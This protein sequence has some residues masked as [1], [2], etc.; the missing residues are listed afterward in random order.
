MNRIVVLAFASIL[1]PLQGQVARA[2]PTIDAEGTTY[3]AIIA[4]AGDTVLLVHGMFS[5]RRAWSGLEEAIA[6]GHRFVAYTQRGFGPDSWQ[7]ATFSRD[8]HTDDLVAILEAL[9]APAD[10]VGWSYGG[11]IVLGAAA[12]VPDRVR[13][14]VVY[15]PFVPELL[16][17]TPE[18]D[19]AAEAFWGLWGPTD[20]AVQAGDDEKA[21]RAAIEA[22]RGLPPGGFDSQDQAARTMQLENAHTVALQWNAPQPTELACDEL[23]TVRAPTLI[24]TGAATLP[25]FTEMGKAIAACMPGAKTAVIDGAAHDAPLAAGQ[26]VAELVLG[27]I[28]AR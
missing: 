3:P 20:A 15:E 18:A 19:A 9:D 26:A 6:R 17:G 7:D 12:E 24:I 8:R 14:V 16:G 4:G 5:D 27:F 10:L 25:A 11:A 2:D 1:L 28:D 13:R 23:G 21:V 22:T